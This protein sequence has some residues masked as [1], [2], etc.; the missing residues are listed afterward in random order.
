MR[1]G[2]SE[3]DLRHA[4]R[5]ELESRMRACDVLIE[6]LNVEQ[7]AVRADV[8]VAGALLEAFEI[9]SDFDTLDR[10]ARQMHAYHR[11]FDRVSL[12]T[13]AAY[14]SAAEKL[15]PPWWGLILAESVDRELRLLERR[16]ASSHPRQEPREIA[17]L[18]WRNEVM[19]VA[20]SIAPDR[21]RARSTREELC[22]VLA[23][24]GTLAD[25]RR[26]VIQELRSRFERR[27]PRRASGST[28]SAA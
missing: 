27:A 13:T 6:E 21:V 25:V 23:D 14:I 8:V 17:A 22:D 18:L 5:R 15:L 24:V 28:S 2:I 26:W 9:K 11:V 1:Y 20:R 10:L 16:A 7:G 4:L 12:V 3:N 19:D